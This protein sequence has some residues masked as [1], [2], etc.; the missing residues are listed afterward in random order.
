MDVCKEEFSGVL[1]GAPVHH[2]HEAAGI[3]DVEEGVVEAE[4]GLLLGVAVVLL[5]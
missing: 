2:V 5:G 3:D 1:L 4:G